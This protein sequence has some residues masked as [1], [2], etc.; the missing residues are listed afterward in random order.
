M[1]EWIYFTDFVSDNRSKRY[2]DFRQLFMEGS[3]FFGPFV[4][5][6]LF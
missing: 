6:G 4:V 1:K 3:G 5:R 2:F